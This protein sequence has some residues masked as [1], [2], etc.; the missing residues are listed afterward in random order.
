MTFLEFKAEQSRLWDAMDQASARL[1]AIAGVS[2]GPMGLTPDSV[3]FSPEYRKARRE[4]DSAMRALQSFNARHVRQFK[5][6]LARERA[7]RLA[8]LANGERAA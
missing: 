1:K 4:F 2:S 5:H 8:S 6:E 7:A 3:K